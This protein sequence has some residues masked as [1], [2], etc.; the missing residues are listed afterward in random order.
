MKCSK[1]QNL[2]SPYL[3]GE[4]D[5]PRA[6]EVEDHLRR[7]AQCQ[8][9]LEEL[10]LILTR[11]GDLATAPMTAD[12]WPAIER[13]ILAQPV[14]KPARA[15]RPVL[16]SGWRPKFAWAFALASLFLISFF[17]WNH[18]QSPSPQLT[19]TQNRVQ[20][21]ADARADI[22]LARSHYENS[23]SGLEQIVTH[24]AHE[25][26]QDR[27]RLY[28]EKLIRLEEII[29]ECSIAI[30]KNTYDATAQRALFNAYDNKIST[31][32]EM[33]VAVAP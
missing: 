24:R 2:L 27:S 4:L 6:T 19:P 33:A 18:L 22:E 30:E 17:L 1:I 10:R 16:L 31:L 26:D 8:Q 12:L 20:R 32:R 14:P 3:D 23:I 21:L 9:A 13:E 11:A 15:P 25:M 29:D 28:R 5:I 7:C